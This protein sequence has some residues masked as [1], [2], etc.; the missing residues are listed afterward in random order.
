MRPLP[1]PV[2]ALAAILLAAPPAAA[3]MRS[4][5]RTRC[6]DTI[7]RTVSV[8]SS[9]Q[10]GYRI[11]NSRSYHDLTRMKGHLR[12]GAY[13]LGLT[14]TEARVSIRVGGQLLTDP[15]SGYECIAPR[16][17]VTL[18]YLPIVVYVGREF[19]PGSCAYEEVLAHEMRH[20]HTYLDY[21]PAAESR[22][23]AALAQRFENKPLYARMGQAQSLLQRE[24]DSGWMP[25][26]KGEM[27]K[28]EALQAAIDSPQ[29]Y[30]R[31]GKVCAGEVQSLV[32]STRKKPS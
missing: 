18:Y 15:G 9:R 32:R 22:V 5:F 1:A 6:E 21:L 26:I 30:A 24:I 20:L 28:V 16:I 11:D 8:L 14:H 13:V 19:P 17:D 12:P 23:R 25:Y 29:E 10:D 3:Q 27:G 31:L 2:A 7:G 4:E